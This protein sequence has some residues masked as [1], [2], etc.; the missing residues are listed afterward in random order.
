MKAIVVSK[1]KLG[2]KLSS[3]FDSVCESVYHISKPNDAI[4]LINTDPP[5]I[6]IVDK[7]YVLEEHGR[8]IQEF[9]SNTLYGHLPIVALLDPQDLDGITWNELSIEDFI[10]TTD[11]NDA[12]SAR[13]PFI[14]SR[15][16]RDLDTN[17]LT[18]LPGNE[19]II[20]HIQRMLDQEQEI[21]IAWLDLD[22]FKPYNDY[23]GFARG[24]EVLLATA[25]I[26][27]T[28]IKELKVEQ[29]FLGH[30]GGDDF[31]LICAMNATKPLCEEIIALFDMVIR[32]FYNDED[33]FQGHIVS[34]DRSGKTKMFPL[35][36]VSIAAVVNRGAKYKH[37]GEA[38]RDATEI[39]EHIKSL[40][41]SNY[42][43]DRRS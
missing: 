7:S 30:I 1:K 43:I 9:R 15:A 4:S 18:H 20:R 26:I 25:R 21:A 22:N 36:T 34:R 5:D 14:V 17:P 13:L 27:T 32:N 6:I 37:Y 3:V 24:D 12:I 2:K 11:S 33:L 29:S 28:A 23:Y 19:S 35:M 40:P 10:L 16:V 39:K 42:M 8:V 38:S 41:G 31:V